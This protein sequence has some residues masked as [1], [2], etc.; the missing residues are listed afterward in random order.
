MD[1]FDFLEV[2]LTLDTPAAGNPFTEAVF[3]GQFG[4]E[5]A[6]AQRVDGFCDSADRRTF[7]LRFMPSVS[8]RHDYKLYFR[9]ESTAL[10][11]SG[12]FLARPTGSPGPVRVDPEHPFHFIRE[13]TGKH[14]FWNSTTTYQLLSWDDAT[15][16]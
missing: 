13:G 9:Q 15:I 2:T 11:H 16:E 7:R 5:G 6:S 8:G 3:S 12:S 10:E 4:C 14:W 1:R